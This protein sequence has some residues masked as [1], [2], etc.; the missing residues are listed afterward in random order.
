MAANNRLDRFDLSQQLDKELQTG[1]LHLDLSNIGW[2]SDIQDGLRSLG[3]LLSAI[4]VLYA[5]GISTAGLNICSAI[6]VRFNKTLRFTRICKGLASLS[7]LSLLA[8]SIVITFVQLKAVDLINTYGN[9]IGLYAYGGNK[10]MI[11][12]WVA[13]MFMLLGASA[14]LLGERIAG[15]NTKREWSGVYQNGHGLEPTKEKGNS[16]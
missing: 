16:I 1:Q 9:D 15:W 5:V 2:P 14:E 7:F 10:Y 8:A 4:F 6:L 11:F 13:V 12:T 3:P